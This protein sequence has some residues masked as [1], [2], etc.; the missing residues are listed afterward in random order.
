MQHTAEFCGLRPVANALGAC[1]GDTN[2]RGM[3]WSATADS[4]RTIRYMAGCSDSVTGRAR[5]AL[6]ASLS[7]FQ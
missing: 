6:I 7:E 4:S 3:G 1:V 2:S 5:I